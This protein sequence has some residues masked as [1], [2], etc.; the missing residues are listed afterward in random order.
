MQHINN[1][2]CKESDTVPH[3]FTFIHL[4]VTVL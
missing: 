3:G 2:G 4:P 1:E